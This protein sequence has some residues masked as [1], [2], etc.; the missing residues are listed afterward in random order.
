[1]G[2]VVFYSL[3]SNLIYSILVNMNGH[4]TDYFEQ[5][6]EVIQ[7]KKIYLANIHTVIALIEEEHYEEAIEYLKD[8]IN[9]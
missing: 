6:E 2:M 1:M 3:T 9:E 4:I 8:M 5:L 7:N